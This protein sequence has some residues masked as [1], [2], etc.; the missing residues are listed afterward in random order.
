M[1]R[2]GG[3]A[4]RAPVRW[5]GTVCWYGG[6]AG[7]RRWYGTIWWYGMVV[8]WDGGAALVLW[9]SGAVRWYGTVRWYGGANAGLGHC[10]CMYHKPPC[11]SH[12]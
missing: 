10:G 2:Y 4:R 1:V 12:F 5:Y 11:R 7:A 9:Y 6:A 8:W 3:T